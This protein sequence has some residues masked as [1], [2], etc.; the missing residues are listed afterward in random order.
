MNT[1]TGDPFE[2]GA[3]V[4]WFKAVVVGGTSIFGGRGTLIGT[5]AGCV[6][7]IEMQNALNQLPISAY[8][9]YIWIGLLTLFAVAVYSV[10]AQGGDWQ[11]L[12]AL[13]RHEN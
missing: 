10:R 8:Y 4:I 11:R 3:L 13:L 9:Q 7:I 2:Q 1:A 6:L 5:L 12:L